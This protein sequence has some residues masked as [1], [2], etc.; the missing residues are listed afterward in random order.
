MPRI[1]KVNPCL[2]ALA[3]LA[4]VAAAAS[5][6]PPGAAATCLPKDQVR[7]TPPASGSVVV[8]I[9]SAG[10][11]V[12]DVGGVDLVDPSGADNA[13]AHLARGAVLALHTTI[14][15]P[16]ATVIDIESP[17]GV[18]ARI[19]GGARLKILAQSDRSES[20][21]TQAG[22]TGFDVPE[23][24]LDFMNVVTQSL[25]AIVKGTDFDITVTSGGTQ[26]SVA[27][28][29]VAAGRSVYVK[30]NADNKILQCIRI[31]ELVSAGNAVMYPTTPEV[32]DFADRAAAHAYFQQQ[33]EAAVAGGDQAFIDDAIKNLKAVDTEDCPPPLGAPPPGGGTNPALYYAGGAALLGAAIYLAT[34]P[35]ETPNVPFPVRTAT[36]TPTPAPTASPTPA[37][38]ASPTPAP[39]ASPSPTPAPTFSP[40]PS[41]TPSP[42]PAPG[43][44]NLSPSTLNFIT[45]GSSAAQ[46][47][48]ASETGYAGNFTASSSNCS[49]IATIAPATS[50]SAFS[51]TPVN[52][53]TCSFTVSGAPGRSGTL[54]VTVTLTGGSIQIHKRRTER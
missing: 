22:Q 20:Y 34:W 37:P 15:A 9:C 5:S 39:T 36:P 24:R 31:M 13:N 49:G 3:A 27:R 23:H 40:T 19:Y 10:S 48:N 42:S 44:V 28:G 16:A 50:T 26:L 11:P 38:T 32:K 12:N 7:Q 43:G 6:A 35:T 14:G 45:T 47:T 54:S 46:S 18:I 51:V 41:P 8:Q 21:A 1:P 52:N 17:A 29:L 4:I 53:G 25:L 2:A 33:Y 30:I